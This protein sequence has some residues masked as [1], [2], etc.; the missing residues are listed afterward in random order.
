MKIQYMNIPVELRGLLE[1]SGG[2]K[3]MKERARIF[4]AT[5][6]SVE[7]ADEVFTKASRWDAFLVNSHLRFLLDFVEEDRPDHY[8][9]VMILIEEAKGT[10]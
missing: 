1:T 10:V 9:Q 4:L 6:Y 3:S 8:A 2:T 5:I 7:E